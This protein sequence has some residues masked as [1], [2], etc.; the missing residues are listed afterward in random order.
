MKNQKN[1]EYNEKV[2]RIFGETCINKKLVHQLRNYELPRYIFEWLVFKFTEN[3]RLTHSNKM[4]LYNLIEKH[5][6]DQEKLEDYKYQ[7]I[8]EK[9]QIKLLNK[10][11]V[12]LNTRTEE[13]NV[14]F[15][16]FASESKDVYIL[17][18][19]ID[20]YRGLLINGLWGIASLVH[21]PT[22]PK[23]ISIVKFT[24]LQIEEVHLDK[25][26]EARKY[27]SIS[28]WINLLINT[29]GLNPEQFPSIY[30]K[31]FLITRLIPYVEKN[32]NLIEMGPKGTGK[33]YLHKNIST[34]VHVVG[35]GTISR[36]Q[37]FFHL[38]NKQ[39]GLLLNNDVVVLDDFSN[40]RI[41]GANEVIGKL[42][43]YMADGI[44]DVG[45]F[46][47]PASSSIV[48]MGNVPLNADGKPSTNFYFRNLPNEMQESAFLDRISAFIPG[49]E[50]HPIRQIDLSKDYGLIG[51][52]FSEILHSLRRKSFIP[53]IDDMVSFYGNKVRTRDVNHIKSTASGLIKLLFPDGEMELEDWKLVI[54][55][56][57]ILRKN[58]IDQLSIIDPEFKDI[59]LNYRITE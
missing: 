19:I 10:Y 26:I 42:K 3:G 6:P 49:W 32:Y 28:E 29:M 56:S 8:K 34:H 58:V 31:I 23:P 43:N 30:E 36:A 4:K 45:S 40:I 5:Y 24:P 50:L 46:K 35:G 51:D 14:Y 20:Q 21:T 41:Q 18:N 47:E 16:F 7:I 57:V 38:G 2:K 22:N 53:Q 37:L 48:I 27:F 25:Y 52:W 59:E 1:Y 39:K 15:P 54:N 12:T 44:I 13:Y 33:S 11:R 17:D 55:F 9:K